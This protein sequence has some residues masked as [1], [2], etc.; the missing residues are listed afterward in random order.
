MIVSRILFLCTY[1]T[2]MDFDKLIK[3]HSLGDNVNYVRSLRNYRIYPLLTH[4][5]KLRDMRSNS[6]RMEKRRRPN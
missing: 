4:G 1:D 5:S 6:Q 3:Q 2:T